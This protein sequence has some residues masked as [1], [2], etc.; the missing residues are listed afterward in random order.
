M[1]LISHRG[2]IDSIKSNLENNPDYIL[3]AINLGYDAEIDIRLI[4]NELFLGHDTPDYKVELS[5]L[6]NLKDCLWVHTKN[7]EALEYLI[8]SDLR[9]FYHQLEAHTIIHNTKLIWSHNLSEASPKSVIPL[10]SLEDINKW[11]QKKVYGICSDY[12]K[13]I[14]KL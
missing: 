11:E 1:K 14:E 8:D 4:G 10:L 7:F 6:L 3:E 12:V 9:I 13:M 2:N 5:W